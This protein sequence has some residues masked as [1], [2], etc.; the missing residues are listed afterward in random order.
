MP[1]SR[2]SMNIL[3]IMKPISGNRQYVFPGDRNPRHHANPQTANMALKRMG[4]QG[5]LVAHGLRSL[6]RTTL[7]EQKFDSELI[8][9]CLS[10]IDKDRVRATYNKA[11]YIKLR[12]EILQW[13]SDHIEKAAEGNLSLSSVAPCK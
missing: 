1:L 8:E 6:A 3:E 9:V 10:H 2:Q 5:E 11:E 13:W 7:N 4:F 12:R